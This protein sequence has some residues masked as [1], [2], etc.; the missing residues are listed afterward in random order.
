MGITGLLPFLKKSTRLASVRE[1]SGGTVAVDAY[2]WLHKGAFACADRL[3]RGEPTDVYVQYCL[4]YVNML[5]THSV[6][7]VLVFDGK[8]LPSKADTESK[9]RENRKKYRALAADHLR[10]GRDKEARECFQRCVDVTPAM[11]RELIKACRARGVDCVVSWDRETGWQICE[12][13]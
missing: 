2:S 8:N 10:A 9:R 5:L 4:R 6:K 1:F 7:P 11:A 12:L 3:A 13:V